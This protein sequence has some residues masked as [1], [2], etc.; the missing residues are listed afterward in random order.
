MSDPTDTST[1]S[2]SPNDVDAV[3]EQL[4]EPGAFDRAEQLVVRLA[5]Q[6]QRVLDVALATGGWF[7]DAHEGAVLKAATAPDADQRIVG[8]RDLV[9]QQTR[10]GMMVGVAIGMELATRLD[11]EAINDEAVE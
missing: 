10:L 3:L 1:A 2:P 5:P 9:S 4:T 6:L 7:D 8:V 11:I